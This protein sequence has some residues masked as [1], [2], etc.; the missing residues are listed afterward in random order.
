MASVSG[1]L[2][3][4]LAQ[5]SLFHSAITALRAE[6]ERIREAGLKLHPNKCWLLSREVTLLGHRI[7]S[8]GIGSR[9]KP[10]GSG[11]SR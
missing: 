5:G 2:V 7:V 10:Y 8:E 4:I 11:L 1:V 3:D 6:L 9:L